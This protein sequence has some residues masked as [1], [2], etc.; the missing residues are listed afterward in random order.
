MS[1]FP[2][3]PTG[4]VTTGAGA[5]R[6]VLERSFRAPI[7]DVWAT[8]TEPDRF[9]RW[10]GP[11]EGEAAPGRTIMVTMAPEDEI[12]ALPATILEC[13]P[14]RRFV[15]DLG[16]PQQPWRIEVDLTEADAVTTMTFVQE[17][18]ENVDVVEVGPGWEYYIDRLTAAID[19]SEMPDW[20]ADGYQD[21]LGPHYAT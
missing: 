5:R 20:D 12:V 11:M 16:D 2:I 15:V 3:G 21:S 1:R 17:L 4:H 14:P 8:L 6:L 7:G 10:Y 19:D 18:T 13:E 9:A